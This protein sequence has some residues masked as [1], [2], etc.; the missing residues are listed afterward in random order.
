MTTL[1]ISVPDELRAFIEAQ[2][3]RD[4]YA[5]ADEFLLALIRDEQRRRA[6]R[7]LEAKFQEAVES[8]PAEPMTAETWAT[9]RR[10]A[11]DGT[12]PDARAAVEAMK[13]FRKGRSLG[14][15]STR[16]MIEEGR[17]F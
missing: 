13:E 12:G 7:A 16:E 1:Q 6:K 5:S 14:G 8:G 17:R 9:L 10:E 11:V 4:G 15:L 3:S 2:V